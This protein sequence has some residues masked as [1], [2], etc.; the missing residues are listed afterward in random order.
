MR[1]R[2]ARRP[3]PGRRSRP[4]GGH[5]A[6]PREPRL[7]HG[8]RPAA[9][10]PG[11]R[12]LRPRPARCGIAHLD[13]VVGAAGRAPAARPRSSGPVAGAVRPLPRRGER[14]GHEALGGHRGPACVA[15]RARPVP[16]TD[17]SPGT[18]TGTRRSAASRR[19]ARVPA[20]GRPI[21]TGRRPP[22]STGCRRWPRGAVQV[23]QRGPGQR[24]GAAVRQRGRQGFAAG[25]PAAD[26]TQ[27][28]RVGG[29]HGGRRAGWGRR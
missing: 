18:R 29:C 6:G 9:R 2:E 16:T 26:R 5:W 23:E 28:G 1:A 19:Y 15:P 22:A 27:P 3:A 25:H 8:P 24:G 21:R 11:R 20:T 10:P 4:G 12:P 7:P 17:S 13:L 14:A